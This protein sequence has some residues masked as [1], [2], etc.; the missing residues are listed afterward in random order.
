[1]CR[2]M[3][4]LYANSMRVKGHKPMPSTSAHVVEMLER[5]FNTME[6]TYGVH[7][8]EE[9]IEGLTGTKLQNWFN[10]ASE[11]WK[12]ATLNN[13]ISILNPF[14]RWAATMS[15]EEGDYIA[16]D[17]SAILHTQS[18]PNP[19]DLPE[20]E[21]PKDKY[22][23][24][25]QVEELLHGG[26]GHN[27]VRDTAIIAMFLWSAIRVSELC[28]VTVGNYREG[29]ARNAVRVQRKGG[30]WKDVDIGDSAYPYVDA[31]LKTRKNL[32]DDQ[33][34]FMTTHGMP[35]TR[36]QIYKCLSYK[37]KQIGIAAGPHALR[38]T[39]LSAQEKEAPLSVV[40]DI[41][42]H[43]SFKITNRYTHSSKQERLAALNALP[44]K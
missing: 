13:Y 44:W 41:A 10:A 21:R 29:K 25:D 37:Q 16:K 20:E 12:P 11:G 3:I 15:G 32:S 42:N 18:I 39:S 34:L 7:V 2:P 14:L 1:M 40:R 8:K 35:C 19:E 4:Q 24:V 38:H 5:V 17:L 36:T 33:P 43:K 22:F 23:S 31:Y 9:K 28:Q 6:E 27:N 30:A 26:H